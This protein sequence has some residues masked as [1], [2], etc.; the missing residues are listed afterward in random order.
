MQRTA[1]TS[2]RNCGRGACCPLWWALILACHRLAA[3]ENQ[4]YAMLVG[5]CPGDVQTADPVCLSTMSLEMAPLLRSSGVV[6]VKDRSR[7]PSN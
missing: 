3:I 6:L 4:R 1:G 7:H 2:P 5:M